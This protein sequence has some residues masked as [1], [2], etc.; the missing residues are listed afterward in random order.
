[1]SRASDWRGPIAT[2]LSQEWPGLIADGGRALIEAQVQQESAGDPRAVSSAGAQGLL[3]LM[4][5]TA[6]EMGLRD[7]FDPAANLRAG[8]RYLRRM[9]DALAAQLTDRGGERV[10]WALAAYNGGIGYVHRALALAAADSK[11]IAGLATTWQLWSVGSLYL[12]HRDCY[13]GGGLRRKRWP[14]YVQILDYVARVRAGQEA[15]AREL[16]QAG[17]TRGGV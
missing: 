10:T 9:Y 1:M 11:R 13:V 6:R 12:M 5:G 17:V 8:V 16:A 15:V 14:D 4:P 3:Q 2:V 7:P